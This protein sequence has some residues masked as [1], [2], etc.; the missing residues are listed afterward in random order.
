MDKISTSTNIS[1]NNIQKI[2][3]ILLSNMAATS[4]IYPLDNM[5]IKQYNNTKINYKLNEL[6]QGFSLG[7]LRQITYGTPNIF[8]YSYLLSKYNKINKN[9]SSFYTKSIYGCISGSIGGLL[10]SPTELI[11][12]KKIQNNNKSINIISLVKNKYNKEGLSSFFKG[13]F[14]TVIR[15]VLYNG[16]RLPI[17]SETK[18]KIVKY[19]PNIDNSIKLHVTSAIISSTIGLIISNPFDVVKTR[20]QNIQSNN[21]KLIDLFKKIIKE[22]GMRTFYKGFIPSFTKC[23]PHAIISFTL[24]ENLNSYYK[25]N[26]L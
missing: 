8:I 9:E 2:S 18:N 25:I 4:V 6:Y 16:S 11:M 13:S 10:G 12:L 20:Y 22:E 1:N 7:L 14:P 17:Y 3:I 5:R 24:L 15:S 26:K 23:I 21:I 19:Y